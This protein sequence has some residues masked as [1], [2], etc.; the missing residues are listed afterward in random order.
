[1]GF[2]AAPDAFTSTAIRAAFG[3]LLFL[4]AHDP[5]AAEVKLYQAA[6]LVEFTTKCNLKAIDPVVGP[7]GESHF[8]AQC[9]PGR[10]RRGLPGCRGRAHLQDPHAREG[11]SP[12]RHITE[13]LR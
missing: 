4:L 3:A 7:P 2:A 10:D 6:R 9:G 12:S 13:T 1:M 8:K 5:A 11:V